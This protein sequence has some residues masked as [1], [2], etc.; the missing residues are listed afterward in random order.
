LIAFTGATIKLTNLLLQRPSRY[1]GW[2]ITWALAV[3]QTVGFGILYYAYS[4][5]IEPM[6]LELGW[7]R[8]QTSLAFSLALLTSGVA[9]LPIGRWVDRHGARGLMTL[10][11]GAATLLMVAWSFAH[12]PLTLY[13]IQALIGLCM[14]AVLYDVAFTVVAVWFRSK[15]AQAMLI[16]TLCAGLASTIFIPLATY[17]VEAFYWR[18]AL[19]ILALILGLTTVPLHAIFLRRHP[20]DLGLI[21]DGT[22]VSTMSPETHLTMSEALKG[23]NFWWLTV[24]FG[25]SRLTMVAIAAHNVPM[26][27]E[28]GH[29]SALV[30][31]VAG[32]IG[33]MQ[34]LGRAF[35]LPFQRFVPLI[36]LAAGIP[37]LHALALLCLLFIPHSISL[38]L[39][40]L[41]FGIANGSGTL[42][43]AALTADIYGSQNYGSISG[44]MALPIALL[45][46]LAP[47]GA[48]ILQQFS[49][50]YLSMLIVLIIASLGASLATWQV[51]TKPEPRS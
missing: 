25:L 36:Q 33:L 14:A 44:G 30:A 24:A 49:G 15:R 6:E 42:A 41:L 50:S 35:Y 18:D 5:F 17:L 34:L 23:A 11:S 31:A 40:A 1:Y 22:P 8:T 20:A 46:T 7:S 37:L 21:P 10:G 27:L 4:V 43:K 48:G 45:Q 16:I 3:T 9:A 47:L 39:F 13:L 28:R 26:L 12:S 38:W 29:S 32:S 19:R 2:Q 51:K